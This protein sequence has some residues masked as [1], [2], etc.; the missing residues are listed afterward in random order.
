MG[1]ANGPG[2]SPRPVMWRVGLGPTVFSTQVVTWEKVGDVSGILF[3][4]HG[5]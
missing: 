1:R 4:A 5:R 3:E 2:R